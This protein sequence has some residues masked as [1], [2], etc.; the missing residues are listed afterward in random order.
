MSRAV[1]R[2]VRN[3]TNGLQDLYA[4]NNYLRDR[5]NRYK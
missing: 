3:K 4:V 5:E 2:K 1:T